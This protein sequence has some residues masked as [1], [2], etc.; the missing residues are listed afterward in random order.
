MYLLQREDNCR[1]GKQDH[2]KET[3]SEDAGDAA[4]GDACHAHEVQET[5]HP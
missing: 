3:V 5:E 4:E 2:G 1:S